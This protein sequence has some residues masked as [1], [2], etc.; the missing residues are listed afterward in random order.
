MSSSRRAA[1]SPDKL[2]SR[3]SSSSGEGADSTSLWLRERFGLNLDAQA[4]KTLWGSRFGDTQTIER[5]A[6][7]YLNRARSGDE[8]ALHRL[9]EVSTVRETHLFRHLEQLELLRAEART[10]MKRQASGYRLRALCAGCATG[11]EPYSVAAVLASVAEELG[12]PG[13]FEVL[14]LDVNCQALEVARTGRYGAWSLRAEVPAWARGYVRVH[15]E[16]EP[17]VAG[18]TET[19]EIHSSLKAGVRFQYLNLA[20]PFLPFLLKGE[21]TF[22]FI[23]C[24]NV[25]MYLLPEVVSRVL[26]FLA[27]Q[28]R[29]EGLLVLAP[30]D[31]DYRPKGFVR[32]KGHAS[33]VARLVE[34]K[35]ERAM[36]PPT[37][38]L[39]AG[40]RLEAS[41][42][43]AP[44]PRPQVA[45]PSPPSE[46]SQAEP[47]ERMPSHA[48]DLGPE[49]TEAKLLA[50]QGRLVPARRVCASLLQK[51]PNSE[52]V[53][54]LA[55]L[56]EVEA[57]SPTEAERLLRAA[58]SCEPSFALAHFALATLLRKT[59]RASESRA[60]LMRLSKLLAGVPPET[61][62]AGPEEVTC[63]WLQS[64]V[65]AELKM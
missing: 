33:I 13:Q 14:G 12:R 16:A 56:I 62:L 61:R 50:D 54:Y 8:E 64:V 21:E 22:D 42:S 60:R 53:M 17:Q 46:A 5:D 31:V 26:D 15:R 19:V 24:R 3:A 47:P 29:P 38:G 51:H 18:R 39:L 11:E 25:L 58:L 23:L 52:V 59:G 1:E 48:E 30:V 41:A 45:V 4:L 35:P 6:V 9:I 55:A 7:D 43:P 20:D 34:A 36:P 27:T 49:L 40:T 10:V 32:F 37:T 63:G 2:R 65:E 57:G 44:R 28:L